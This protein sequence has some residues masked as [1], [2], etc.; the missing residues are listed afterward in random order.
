[1]QEGLYSPFRRGVG[2]LLLGQDRS[3]P[4]KERDVVLGRGARLLEVLALGVNLLQSV[5][6]VPNAGR[7][8]KVNFILVLSQASKNS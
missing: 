5:V 6:V 8:I 4:Y 7:Q 3:S 2:W 1:M